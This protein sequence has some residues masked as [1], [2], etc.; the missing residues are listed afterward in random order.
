MTAPAN[1]RHS[2][3]APMYAL[4][5]WSLADNVRDQCENVFAATVLLPNETFLRVSK[6]V[7]GL[8]AAL[9]SNA[10]NIKKLVRTQSSQLKGETK[11]RFQMRQRRARVLS[12]LLSGIA[13]DELLN[14]KIRNTLE[15]F[16][17]YLDEADELLT[18]KGHPTA[19]LAMSNMVVSH[20]EH[21][22]G[23][24]IFPIRVYI[25]SERKFYNMKWSIDLGKLHAESQMVVERLKN[26]PD[27]KLV[28]GAGAL[29]VKL[30]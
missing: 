14:I 13:L 26:H 20:W 8:I 28:T 1:P 29:C 24:K 2:L 12:E 19:T 21:L 11:T 15:H 25:A 10:A 16:D 22:A 27:T 4:E 23:E 5:L 18:V 6:E 7:H 30:R 3:L 9:L 17:E